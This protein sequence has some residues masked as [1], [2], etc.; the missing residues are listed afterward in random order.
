MI[1][2]TQE[3]EVIVNNKNSNLKT[4]TLSSLIN[5]EKLNKIDFLKVDIEEAI[6][7]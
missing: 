3:S 4:I 1:K 6:I 7:K 2:N 5:N